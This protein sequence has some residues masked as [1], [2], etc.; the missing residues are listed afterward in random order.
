MRKRILVVAV[1]VAGVFACFWRVGYCDFVIYD[2]PQYL[3]SNEYIRLGLS[4]KGIAWALSSIHFSNWHPLTTISYL[5]EYQFFR[6]NPVV[7]HIDNL[8]LHVLATVLLF[9][10]LLSMT[11]ALWPSALVAALFG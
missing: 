2:D 6:L 5:T 7:F 1:L 10:V 4:L 9:E 11:N 3:T 8:I